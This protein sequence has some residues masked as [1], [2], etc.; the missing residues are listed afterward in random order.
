MDKKLLDKMP[1][2]RRRYGQLNI[3]IDYI[4]PKTI[5]E[6]GTFD[7]KRAINLASTALRNGPCHYIGF[8]VFGDTD[9]EFNEKEY[10]EKD[11]RT[12]VTLEGVTK[13]LKKFKEANPGFTFELVK[14]DT[15]ETLSS[16][17]FPKVDLAYIDGGHSVETI[18]NDY[19]NL[20]HAKHIVFDDYYYPEKGLD[21]SSIGCNKLVESIPHKILPCRNFDISLVYVGDLV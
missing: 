4:K 10:N 16:F 2:C 18:E 13:Q 3:L 5:V 21:V 19:N 1:A 14:G 12:K 6:V 15:N 20:K 17:A 7:G 8:D 9:K 11:D